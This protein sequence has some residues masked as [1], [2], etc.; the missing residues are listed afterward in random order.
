MDNLPYN[1]I[2]YIGMV[3]TDEKLSRMSDGG[4]DDVEAVDIALPMC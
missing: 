2:D 3:M 1:S 4:D